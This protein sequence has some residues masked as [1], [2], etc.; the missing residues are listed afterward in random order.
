MDADE[1]LRY[2]QL[3]AQSLFPLLPVEEGAELVK[4]ILAVDFTSGVDELSEVELDL[5]QRAQLELQRLELLEQ[6]A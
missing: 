4:E 5:F 2:A 3:I 1:A 6:G